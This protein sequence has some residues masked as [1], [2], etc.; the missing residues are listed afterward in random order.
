M[1][2]VLAT[3]L[4]TLLV[5]ILIL[6]GRAHAQTI[7]FS[8]TT[9]SAS[10]LRYDMVSFTADLRQDGSPVTDS[11]AALTGR[12]LYG[13]QP[14]TTV[15]DIQTFSL[16]FNSTDDM[17]HG[18]WALPW[19]PEIGAYT[20]EVTADIGGDIHTETA[21]FDVTARE[22]RIILPPGY[23]AMNAENVE[24]LTGFSVPGPFG[25]AGDWLNMF[26]WAEFMGADSFWPTAGYIYGGY[27]GV[28]NQS[29]PWCSVSYQS[30][31]QYCQQATAHGFTCAPWIWPYSAGAPDGL[32]SRY[33]VTFNWT[34]YYDCGDSA[35][36]ERKG[37][38]SLLDVNAFDHTI[39][40]IE[41]LSARPDVDIIG[42]D[43]EPAGNVDMRLATDEFA[44]KMNLNVPSEW[45][46]AYTAQDKMEWVGSRMGGIAASGCTNYDANIASIWHRWMS[47][48]YAKLLKRLIEES[49][50]TKAFFM[51]TWASNLGRDGSHDPFVL[52]DAGIDIIAPM[53]YT[54][55]SGISSGQ[56]CWYEGAV[57]DR[58]GAELTYEKFKNLV[59]GQM[60]LDVAFTDCTYTPYRDPP[61]P[62]DMY[63]RMMY[64]GRGSYS[65]GTISGLFWH[66]ILRAVGMGYGSPA[67]YTAIEYAVTGGAAASELRLEAGRDPINMT[68]EVPDEAV[69][70]QTIEGNV[71][72][73]NLGAST[74]NVNV[75]LVNSTRGWEFV[76]PFDTDVTLE[77]SQSV[78]IP[79]TVRANLI[80]YDVD[81]RF[82]IATKAKWG[83]ASTD[84]H[85]EFKYIHIEPKSTISGQLKDINGQPIESEITVYEKDT[86]N[87]IASNQTDT[88]G[89]FYIF[90][91]SG[92]YDV[93]YKLTS[94]PIKDYTIKIKSVDMGFDVANSLRH[95]TY[96]TTDDTVSIILETENPWTIQIESDRAPTR[97]SKNGTLLGYVNSFTELGINKYFYDTANQKLHIM[98]NRFLTG[99]APLFGNDAVGNDGS[100]YNVYMYASGPYTTD[101]P[102][103]VS[104]IYL[105][106]PVAGNAKVALYAESG[107]DPESLIV[108]SGEQYCS[109]GAW[110]VFD[111]ADTQTPA[112]TYFL[113]IK[114]DTNN[115]MSAV[116]RSGFGRWHT[117]SYTEPFPDPFESEGWMGGEYSIYACCA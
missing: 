87:V 106:T 15:G 116:A 69:Y 8:V 93:S 49:G 31:E 94:F 45:W 14:V 83:S 68:I 59:Q 5:L 81:N 58:Y 33:G 97:I 70:G 46:T 27:C 4:Q 50:S 43:W 108:A 77:P 109:A 62:E 25:E 60:C 72:V 10:Y 90:I 67:P 105:Y 6:A 91:P 18:Y 86:E 38:I 40:M 2:K 79:F 24:D 11:S 107:N 54:S 12:V 39:K 117:H 65:D 63:N 29:F 100:G 115:M 34:M 95:V 57:I 71:I 52:N 1:E 47:Y 28:V 82:M 101:E 98:V 16:Y 102:T 35:L 21:A 7:D 96:N 17:W 104:L 61:A 36:K 9:E 55:P 26:D 19:N 56:S 53:T 23:L 112:G 66:D 110:N 113:A 48:Q 51:Y 32:E 85:L 111:V 78:S 75:Y 88:N 76:L 44:R 92:I 20:L 73:K 37:D 84:T 3:T 13:G 42:I 103:T 89:D 22:P 64:S 41:I 80:N 114:M 99:M 30:A 74:L